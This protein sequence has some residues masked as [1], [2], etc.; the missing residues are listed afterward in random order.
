[1]AGTAHQL[2]LID[3]VLG[4]ATQQSCCLRAIQPIDYHLVMNLVPL[5]VLI[6]MDFVFIQII[7]AL[8]FF[9]HAERPIDRRAPDVENSLDLI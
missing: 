7:D 4:I 8:E 9:T 3:K 5:A 1:M 6:N 2:N